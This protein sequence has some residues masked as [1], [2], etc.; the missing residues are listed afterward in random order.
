MIMDALEGRQSRDHR[1]AGVNEIEIARHR[2]RMAGVNRDVFGVEPALGIG[3]AVGVYRISNFESADV[4]S[5][6]GDR[7]GPIRS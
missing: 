5:H 4:R 3:E 2:S 6:G 7:A 1:R